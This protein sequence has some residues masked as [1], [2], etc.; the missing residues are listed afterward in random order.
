MVLGLEWE[1]GLWAS[2]LAHALS[3]LEWA[4]LLERLWVL[5]LDTTKSHLLNL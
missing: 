4:V 3:A 2:E 1:A 5:P